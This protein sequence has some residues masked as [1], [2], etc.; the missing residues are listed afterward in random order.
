[1]SLET[2]QTAITA[3]YH[4]ALPF[5]RSI[6]EDVLQPL[7]LAH[8][9]ISRGSKVIQWEISDLKKSLLSK[10]E[11][12]LQ[13]HRAY[14]NTKC[15]NI[16]VESNEEISDSIE[17]S[18]NRAY[19]LE[20][21]EDRTRDAA[22]LLNAIGKSFTPFSDMGKVPSNLTP[23]KSTSSTVPVRERRCRAIDAW[24]DLVSFTRSAVIKHQI[25][26]TKLQELQE[27]TSIAMTECLK[28][29][30]IAESAYLAA[31]QYEIQVCF[32]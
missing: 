22:Q 32:R 8:S 9:E 3:G 16:S 25:Y 27:K 31:R 30:V 6:L 1:M 15:I 19:W 18:G 26:L 21:L 29:F 10:Q 24:N 2:F 13:S 4:S 28:K 20:R 14:S 7:S 17:S 12:Y 23:I 5:Q 11:N